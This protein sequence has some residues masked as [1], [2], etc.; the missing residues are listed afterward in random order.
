MLPTHTTK[1]S[2]KA[3]L[4]LKKNVFELFNC[5]LKPIK[6]EFD[7]HVEKK[8]LK[9]KK[10]FATKLIEVKI[11]GAGSFRQRATLSSDKKLL[12]RLKKKVKCQSAYRHLRMTNTKEGVANAMFSFFETPNL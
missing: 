9:T 12:L 3:L 6:S 7:S 5:R 4:K 8:N 1:H 10:S 11:R 2:I